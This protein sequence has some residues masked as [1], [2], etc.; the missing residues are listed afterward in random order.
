M[1]ISTDE[2]AVPYW[3]QMRRIWFGRIN[4]GCADSR[5][6]E[7]GKGEREEGGARCSAIWAL[8]RKAS[9]KARYVDLRGLK[10]IHVVIERKAKK[11]CKE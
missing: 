4:K 8:L 7:A 9:S 11:G 6:R 10:V 5:R 2:D 1:S 3:T